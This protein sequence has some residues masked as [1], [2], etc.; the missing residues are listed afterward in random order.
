[1]KEFDQAE[2][3][4]LEREARN[5]IRRKKINVSEIVYGFDLYDFGGE[6]DTV[7]TRLKALKEEYSEDG[8]ELLINVDWYYDDVSI[9]L[10][11]KGSRLETDKEL[12]KRKK[13]AATKARKAYVNSCGPEGERAEKKR[14]LRENIKALQKELKAL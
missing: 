13:T 6:L 12:E 8:I 4:R 11:K 7:I 10:R 5:K 14:I 3:D 9:D 1:M 2:S